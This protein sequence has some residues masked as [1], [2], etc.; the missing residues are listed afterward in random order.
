MAHFANSMSYLPEMSLTG[1]LF[2]HLLLILC[3]NTVEPLRVEACMAEAG[4]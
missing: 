3:W 2:E 1:L 4:H